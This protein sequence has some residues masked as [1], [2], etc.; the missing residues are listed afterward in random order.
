MLLR[1]DSKVHGDASS[2]L[3]RLPG[4]QVRPEA[5][6]ATAGFIELF[7]TLLFTLTVREQDAG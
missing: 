2:R 1:G 5:P 7:G 3:N 4:L 6:F